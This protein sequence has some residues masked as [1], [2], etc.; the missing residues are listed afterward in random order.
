MNTIQNIVQR[1]DSTQ[2]RHRPLAFGYAVIKKYGEDEA[3]SQAALITYYAYLALFPLL[4]VLTTLTA[5]VVGDHHQKL[6]N[7]I[8]QSITNY[9]PV[10]G[11][12]LSSH[13]HTLHKNGIAL[14][15]GVLFTLYGTRGVADAFR[16]GVQNI[17]HVPKTQRDG[18]PKSTL[19][20]LCLIIIG[21]IGFLLASVSAGM[22]GSVGR[23]FTFR[24]LSVAV[25]VFI[26]YWLFSLLLYISLRRHVAIK[27]IRAG[28]A[29]AAIGLV[30][31]QALG[32][33]LL[34]RELK[35]LD[36]L[37][38]YF[39]ISLGLLFWIYLQ[40][41]VLLYAIEISSVSAHKYWPR[42]LSGQNLTAAD[43]KV[44]AD[45]RKKSLIH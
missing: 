40:A 36:A 7:D 3:G 33:Y 29:T 2:R 42:S 15:I 25:N 16:H 26:L 11:S 4:L 32:G 20:S 28:A 44:L 30:I 5:T 34:T 31:L 37:Y 41:Q 39:A 22:A 38:S 24:L 8:I 19:K 35:S 10:L 18:F 43:H 21:G 17:W 1:I 13:I 14:V 12:Q 6:Q 27:S 9:F 45:H 23:G